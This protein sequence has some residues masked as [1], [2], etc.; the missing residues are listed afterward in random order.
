MSKTSVVPLRLPAAAGTANDNADQPPRQLSDGPDNHLNRAEVYGSPD[1]TVMAL[2]MQVSRAN[3]RNTNKFPASAPCTYKDVMN[4]LSTVRQ[5]EKDGRCMVGG[6]LAENH[7]SDRAVLEICIVGQDV[8]D[9]SYFAETV[10]K[11]MDLG[12]EFIGYLTHS[13][14]KAEIDFL[15]DGFAKWAER[16]EL[17]PKPTLETAKRYL[18]SK[19]KWN[20]DLVESAHELSERRTKDGTKIIVHTRP[21]DR[22]RMMFPLQE[23]YVVANHGAHADAIKK[24]GEV[25]LGLGAQ[26]GLRIDI[27]SRNISRLFYLPSEPIG[28]NKC[29]IVINH[30]KPLDLNSIKPMSVQDYHRLFADPFEALGEEMAGTQRPRPE[31]PSGKSLNLWAALFAD[32]FDIARAFEDHVDEADERWRGEKGRDKHEFQCPFDEEHGTNPGDPEDKA[33]CFESA[34]PESRFKFKC[35]HDSC[36]GY[37]NLDLLAKTL[38]NGTLPESVLTDERYSIATSEDFSEK[39][40]KFE[41]ATGGTNDDLDPLIDRAVAEKDR[42]GFVSVKTMDALMEG[43]ARQKNRVPIYERIKASKIVAVTGFK[44]EVES[45]AK[46]FAR[47]AES[48]RRAKDAEGLTG[49]DRHYT[50]LPEGIRA[51]NKELALVQRGSGVVF[52]E[53][54]ETDE[55][56]LSLEAA[57]VVYRPWTYGE[58]YEPLFP[59][60]V[61]S[62]YRDHRT[63]IVFKPYVHGTKDLT[64]ANHLNLYRGLALEPVEGDCMDYYRHVFHI[65][66]GGNMRLFKYVMTWLAHMMQEPDKKPGTALVL[67]GLKGIGKG[68]FVD[69]LRPILGRH[70]VKVSDPKQLTGNFN[71]HMDAKILA[72]AEEAFFGGDRKVDSIVKDMITSD[73]MMLERKFM[74]AAEID[75]HRRFIFLSNAENVVRATP[76]ERRYAVTLV[77]PEQMHN[78]AYWDHF[79]SRI[80]SGGL[81]A[82]LAYDLLRLDRDDIGVDLRT[83]PRTAALMDQILTNQSAEDQWLRGVLTGGAFLDANGVSL[84][85][86]KLYDQWKTQPLSIGKDIVYESYRAEVG[87]YYGKEVSAEKIGT[88]LLGMFKETENGDSLIGVEGNGRDGRNYVLPPL[89]DLRSYY[90]DHHLPLNHRAVDNEDDFIR[91]PKPEVAMFPKKPETDDKFALAAHRIECEAFEHERAEVRAEADDFIRKTLGLDGGAD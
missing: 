24:Y 73:R 55:P 17:D 29:Q 23:R 15:K 9:G 90:E 38:A 54:R 44:N 60:W 31:T 49:E 70:S 48:K 10:Q 34:S 35:L 84:G 37:N 82:A 88:Y 79:V 77:P 14:G 80:S 11:G 67:R 68:I 46:L 87:T 89:P 51:M 12:Y 18:R 42:D 36:A 13:S 19:R 71:G 74:D 50:T 56:W 27:A 8:E 72:I 63:E 40:A 57:P 7:R 59:E 78:R 33:C 45:R 41:G 39:L 83:P 6:T 26:F 58:D 3:T 81:P 69:A 66:C 85:T 20:D 4:G 28:S 65:I 25:M 75:D 30:G 1:P 76:D 16:S 61:A 21:Y 22:Y 43:V 91:V 62:S 64:P 2:P 53:K 32:S 47:E 5:G 86:P 52:Y